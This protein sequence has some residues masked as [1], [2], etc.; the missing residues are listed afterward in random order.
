MKVIQTIQS[1]SLDGNEPV[2]VCFYTGDSVA[3][4][5]GAM[6]QAVADLERPDRWFRILS[7]RLEA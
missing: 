3:Q 5:M 7:V 1:T 6:A 4:A 2:E